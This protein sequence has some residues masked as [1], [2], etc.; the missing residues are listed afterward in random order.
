MTNIKKTGIDYF[1]DINLWK[2][3]LKLLNFQIE[4]KKHNRHFN[5]L[6]MF[7]YER[8]DKICLTE[9]PEHYFK[10]KIAN[11]L[12]Y[13]LQKEFAIFSYVIPLVGRQER[14]KSSQGKN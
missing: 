6:S 4:Y 9:N 13:G 11:N 7:Y 3:A 8:L 14:V 2:D 5:T 12:F 10:I 1:I